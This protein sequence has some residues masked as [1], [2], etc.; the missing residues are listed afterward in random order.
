MKRARVAHD[1]A[2]QFGWN[3]PF[4][5]IGILVIAIVAMVAF[6]LGS[7]TFLGL[8]FLAYWPLVLG[9]GMAALIVLS[10]VWGTAIECIIWMERRWLQSG[11]S[12]DSLTRILLSDWVAQ[13]WSAAILITFFL[14]VCVLA[15]RQYQCF[16]VT[17]PVLFLFVFAIMSFGQLPIIH[18][19]RR[20]GRD[21]AA[22]A[23]LLFL[24][25]VM[26]F[27]VGEVLTVDHYRKG[28]E[29]F[30][31]DHSAAFSIPSSDRA[32]FFF[33]YEHREVVLRTGLGAEVRRSFAD[34]GCKQADATRL[35]QGCK[36][37]RAKIAGVVPAAAR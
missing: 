32:D 19:L 23:A 21:R 34:L 33:D 9:D 29:H 26:I 30:H 7:F 5:G 35:A 27:L 12:P 13:P 14:A 16:L 20:E 31:N 8:Q 10:A 17:T 11:T 22:F 37:R 28:L 18:A 2:G 36:T 4:G 24:A 1:S 25:A 6:T 15:H 3:L